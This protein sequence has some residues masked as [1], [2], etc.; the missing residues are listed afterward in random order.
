MAP[1]TPLMPNEHVIKEGRATHMRSTATNMGYNLAMGWGR[2]TNYRFLMDPQ[3]DMNAGPVKISFGPVAY[4]LQHVT[5]ASVA[6]L[7]V[8]WSTRNVMRLDFDNGGKEFF[9]FDDDPQSWLAPILQAKEM[10]PALPYNTVPSIKSGV[11]N[12][13]PWRFFF[14]VLGSI[15]ACGVVGCFVLYIAGMVME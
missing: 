9:F 15:M 3:L 6:P 14:T 11:E 7:K 12:S 2:V 4:P 8:Q 5:S 1:L 10:A 13:N